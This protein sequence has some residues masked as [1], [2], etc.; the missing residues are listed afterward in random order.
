MNAHARESALFH[1][2]RFTDICLELRRF[3]AKVIIEALTPYAVVLNTRHQDAANRHTRVILLHFCNGRL[4]ALDS[5]DAI[6]V[7]IAGDDDLFGSHDSRPNRNGFGCG[8]VN[9]DVVIVVF[10]LL[11]LFSQLSSLV[12]GHI[13]SHH[14]ICLRKLSVC[15]DDVYAGNIGIGNQLV[16]V[17]LRIYQQVEHIAQALVFDQAETCGQTAVFIQVK[18][19]D[20]LSV[21][22]CHLGS[23]CSGQRRLRNA[24]LIIEKCHHFHG[25]PSS[26]VL[27]GHYN[28][29]CCKCQY[30]TVIK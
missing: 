17:G 18:A 3:G 5:I 26:F 21:V 6:L 8:A 27:W 16:R 30:K 23:E 20:F 9:N 10:D 13:I 11:K 14:L 12:T 7:R 24:A 28:P 25:T 22:H 19:K 29:S 2:D 1:I 15:A 4:H